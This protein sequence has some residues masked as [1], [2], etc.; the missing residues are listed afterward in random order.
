[1][2]MSIVFEDANAALCLSPWQVFGSSSQSCVVFFLHS[3]IVQICIKLR[4]W[5]T[6][7]SR[8]ATFLFASGL[9][10]ESPPTG[11]HIGLR[12]T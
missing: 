10:V 12:D 1:M 3:P 8:G 9:I 7:L 11:S 6:R 5:G 4:K 2:L